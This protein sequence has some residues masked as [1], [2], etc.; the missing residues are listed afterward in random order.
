MASHCTT[1][2][3][4]SD[5]SLAGKGGRARAHLADEFKGG[6]ITVGPAA[7]LVATAVRAD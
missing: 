2:G 7:A 3:M 6:S 1:E 4:T 5:L